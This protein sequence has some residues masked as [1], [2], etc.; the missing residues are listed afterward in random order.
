[1]HLPK[2]W[3]SCQPA[4]YA[5]ADMGH[6]FLTL[7]NFLH[8]EGALHLIIQRVVRINGWEQDYYKYLYNL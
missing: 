2:S 5:Q 6:Y 8:V 3:D 1:M 7:V 4:Q